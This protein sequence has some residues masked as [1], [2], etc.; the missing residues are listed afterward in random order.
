MSTS[1]AA[2]R[3]L[4]VG[5]SGYIGGTVLHYLLESSH[6][7][8]SES[9]ITVLIRG[10]DRAQKLTEVYGDR[11]HPL[12]FSG[13]DD[14]AH[15]AAV[16]SEHDVVVSAAL[17]FHL[18]G[19]RALVR[20]LATRRGGR[21]GSDGSAATAPARNRP[22]IVH[23]SGVSNIADAPPLGEDHPERRFD[24]AD[25]RAVYEHERREEARAPYPQRTTELAV[26]DDAEEAG[27]GAIAVQAPAV[28]GTGRGLFAVEASML[29]SKS[30]WELFLGE[31]MCLVS[32]ANLFTSTLFPFSQ[33][34]FASSWTKD[35]S[36]N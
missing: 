30:F 27:V 4:L 23:L 35:I 29:S 16:A 12:V 6:P 18:P 21:S 20:G 1:S 17:G 7:V 24:D 5:A 34:C 8:L 36:S 31:D 13:L 2:P 9:T 11:V 32:G 28:F 15:V 26:L 14:T 33:P 25:A 10:Q 3:I 19:A 22:W